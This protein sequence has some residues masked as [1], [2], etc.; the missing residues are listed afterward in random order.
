MLSLSSLLSFVKRAQYRMR[1]RMQLRGHGC[2]RK[3]CYSEL[4]API[5]A[6]VKNDN[7]IRLCRDYK[8]TVNSVLNI[9]DGLA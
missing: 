6:V 4:A 3:S 5:V 7:S 1:L 8:V 2:I 9:N